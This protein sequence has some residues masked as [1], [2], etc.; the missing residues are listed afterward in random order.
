VTNYG[1]VITN[2]KSHMCFRL[3]QN[4]VTLDDLERR[5][6]PNHNVISPKLV[7]FGTDYVKVVEDTLILSERKCRPKSL[8]LSDI[9]FMAIL[10]GD[11]PSESVKAR[12]CPLASENLTDNQP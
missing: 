8:V 5:N 12:Q 1:T 6:S 2:R 7:A 9:S 4:S 11:H 3:V 10:A